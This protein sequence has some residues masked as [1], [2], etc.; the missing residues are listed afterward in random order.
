MVPLVHG[1]TVSTQRQLEEIYFYH[2]RE[3]GPE[4]ALCSVLDR[5]Q[6]VFRRV[7]GSDGTTFWASVRTEYSDTCVRGDCANGATWRIEVPRWY[8]ATR[9]MDLS[10]PVET[11]FI[12]GVDVCD[13]CEKECQESVDGYP[14]AP[15]FSNGRHRIPLIARDYNRKFYG[16][17][18][19]NPGK[20]RTS[21]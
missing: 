16:R 21:D 6:G 19:V 7:E 1:L 4:F 9:R 5:W 17:I 2:G 20:A 14:I 13:D 10:S 18:F 3:I 15:L 8:A 12:F 11:D